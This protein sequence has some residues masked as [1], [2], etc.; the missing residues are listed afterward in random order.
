VRI[1]SIDGGGIRGLIP[2]LVLADLEARTGKPIH[3]LFDL[4]AGTSTGGIL[5]LGLTTAGAAGAVASAEAMSRIYVEEGDRIFHR[6]VHDRIRA[7][8]GALD[9]KYPA[10]G[11]EGVFAEHFGNARLKD[12]LTP[13]LITAYETQRL[14][15][16]FFRSE[17]A[18]TD[19]AYDYPVRDAARATSA[20]PVYFEP[21]LIRNEASGEAY[22]LIDGGVF[23]NS[24]AM[25]AMVD[26]RHAFG[27]DES[28]I[29]L[30]SLGTG[31]SSTPLDHERIR[32]WGALEWVRPVVDVLFD[33]VADVTSFQLGALLDPK[34][35]W[36]LQVDLQASSS[37]FDDI[38]PE[39]LKN[40][41]ADARRMIEAEATSLDAIAAALTD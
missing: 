41:A 6:S 20:A 15:A 13:V 18:K 34:H 29:V 32:N 26:A 17:R 25:C 27:A 7:A 9:E 19:P 33:G 28:G 8:D 35:Y 38:R 31:R 16:F 2:A 36:R 3:E 11:I 12:A 24:P 30:V 5:A 14:G 23:A 22:S 39:N 1:L 40:L 21:S 37:R 10:A 4:I